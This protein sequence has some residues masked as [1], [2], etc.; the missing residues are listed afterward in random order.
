M[1]TEAMA[2][3][4]LIAM[5][6]K[7]GDL[8]EVAKLL[9]YA[10]DLFTRVG[11]YKHA[12]IDSSFMIITMAID[13]F[14]KG[15]VV[16]A[17]SFLQEAKQRLPKDFV[18]SILEDKVKAGWEPLRYTLEIMKD[19]D[20]YAR[21]I[22]TEKGFSFESRMRELIRKMLPQYPEIESKTA[23]MHETRRTRL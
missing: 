12:E 20:A 21:K 9:A 11:D 17:N 3:E 14:H 10:A 5:V 7:K 22:E 15:D 16:N 19:F 23:C 18:F 6:S 1:R 2:D 4:K 13:A 8:T